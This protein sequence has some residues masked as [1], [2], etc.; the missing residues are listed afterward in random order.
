MDNKIICINEKE[1]EEVSGGSWG[2]NLAVASIG[3]GIAVFI[4]HVGR[5]M[6]EIIGVVDKAVNKESN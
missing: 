5:R 1:L 2:R 3:I 6:S 4:G